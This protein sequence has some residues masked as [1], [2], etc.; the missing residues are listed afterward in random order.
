MAALGNK[1]LNVLLRIYS[2]FLKVSRRHYL[3]IAIRCHVGCFVEAWSEV[4]NKARVDGQSP[5]FKLINETAG[6]YIFKPLSDYS[7]PT[8]T[9]RAILPHLYAEYLYDQYYKGNE[10]KY[11]RFL[12]KHRHIVPIIRK[13]MN[14]LNYSN[15]L[16]TQTAA[17]LN[18]APQVPST[19]FWQSKV[20]FEQLPPSIQRIS[21]MS[22]CSDISINPFGSQNGRLHAVIT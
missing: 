7:T 20:V 4:T 22:G 5:L 17:K 8:S 19:A 1:F 14:L 12:L 15:Y 10:R 11:L 21:R 6:Y 16:G 2:F 9:E 18:S 3:K 13:Y